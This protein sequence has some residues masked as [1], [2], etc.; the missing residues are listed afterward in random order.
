M[1]PDR[2]TLL[3][4]GIRLEYLT[5]GWNSLEAVVAVVAGLAAGSIA[6]VGFGLDSVV[7]VLAGSMLLWRLRVEVAHA[8]GECA[9]TEQAERRALRFVG[10]T[11]FLLALYVTYESGRKLVNQERPDESPLG[12][13]LAATSLIL[14]P[15]LAL[16]K[17]RVA[18]ALGS[19]ALAADAKETA[20]CSYLSL[21]L[22]VGLGANALW[23]WWWADPVAALAM[24]PLML[25]EGAEALRGESCATDSVP[26]L[27]CDC[28]IPTCQPE[29]CVCVT[30]C[31][32]CC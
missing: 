24:I 14:M 10:V 25:K 19:R 29:R 15:L 7:E 11:F 9:D 30:A 1:T 27:C 6:L 12:L 3:R 18:R 22:V 31:L 21:A 16:A 32:C 26:A 13:A 23:G 8:H 4:R 20:V 17:L 2:S 5:V 28:C